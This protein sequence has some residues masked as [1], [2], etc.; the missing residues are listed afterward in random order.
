M[1]RSL[2][3]VLLSAFTALTFP[4]HAR[5]ADEVFVTAE[6]AIRGYDPVAY[7]LQSKPVRGLPSI[8]HRWRGADWRFANVANRDRFAADPERYAPRFGGY[9]AFGTAQGY[10]VSTDPR[11]FAVVDGRLYLNNSRR[12]QLLWDLDRPGYIAKASTNW[13]TLEASPYTN[14]E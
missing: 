6:G 10:K 11:A 14:D 2:A 8:T 9:C 1:L 3:L 5:A 7:H 12:V 4:H 13:T